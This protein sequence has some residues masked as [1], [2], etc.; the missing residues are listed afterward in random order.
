MRTAALVALLTLGGAYQGVASDHF[1]E[2]EHL[3]RLAK[4]R[5]RQQLAE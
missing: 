5:A 3:R 4:A 1:V 2:I